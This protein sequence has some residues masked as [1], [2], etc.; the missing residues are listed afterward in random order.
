MIRIVSAYRLEIVRTKLREPIARLNGSENTARHYA[1]L[2]CYDRERLIRVD[3]DAK[4]QVVGEEV[5][6]IGTIAATLVSPREVF[7]GAILNN[8]ASI[9]VVH[10][11]PSGCPEPSDE[12][13]RV[14]KVLREAGKLLGIPV[15]DFLIIGEGGRYWSTVGGEDRVTLT[16]DNK[17]VR[18]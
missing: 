14:N 9:L 8:A 18:R 5:V 12:D 11:H 10:N 4:N 1:Y 6:S 3:L 13:K 16:P 17:K 15:V 2:E 7:K